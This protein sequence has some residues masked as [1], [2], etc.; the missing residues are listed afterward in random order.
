MCCGWDLQSS[1]RTRRAETGA[2]GLWSCSKVTSCLLWPQN[3]ST[4]RWVE[5]QTLFTPLDAHTPLLRPALLLVHTDPAPLYWESLVNPRFGLICV[6]WCF[7]MLGV[8][9]HPVSTRWTTEFMCSFI[10]YHRYCNQRLIWIIMKDSPKE[11][12]NIVGFQLDK[13]NLSVR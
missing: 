11:A 9:L 4:R 6:F 1:D 8:K 5:L 12:S 2:G 10:L 13:R 3:V 7:I